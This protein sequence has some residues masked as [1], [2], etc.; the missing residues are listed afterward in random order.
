MLSMT[1]FLG[2]GGPPG[3]RFR[4]LEIIDEFGTLF[5]CSLGAH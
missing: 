5:W 1:A 3:S 4:N 2:I